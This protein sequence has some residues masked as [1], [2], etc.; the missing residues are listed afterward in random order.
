MRVPLACLAENNQNNYYFVCPAGLELNT[1][2]ARVSCD[3]RQWRR[4]LDPNA[5]PQ[6]LGVGRA[7]FIYLQFSSQRNGGDDLIFEL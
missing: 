7:F 1:V 2:E 6:D 4:A 5:A 3:A